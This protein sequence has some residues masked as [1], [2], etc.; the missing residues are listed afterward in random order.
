MWKGKR[1]RKMVS[2]SLFFFSFIFHR[3]VS[4]SAFSALL[5]GNKVDRSLKRSLSSWDNKFFDFLLSSFSRFSS[6]SPDIS[7]FAPAPF[8]AHGRPMGP[9]DLGVQLDGRGR[10]MAAVPH[11]LCAAL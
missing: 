3:R 9:N 2:L 11:A 7:F 1:R 6:A 4:V 10:N 8:G 5:A